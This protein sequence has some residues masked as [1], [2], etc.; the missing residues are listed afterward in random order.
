MADYKSFDDY[1]NYSLDKRFGE[2]NPE[3]P[4]SIDV[5]GAVGR[6]EIRP[7]EEIKDD[8]ETIVKSGYATA[9]GLVQG[10]LGIFGEL[11]HVLNGIANIYS[12]PE[13]QQKIDAFLEGMGKK[14][15]LPDAMKMRELLNKVIPEA[16]PEFEIAENIAEAVGPGK[17][18][19]K[20]AAKAAKG[21]KESKEAAIIAPAIEVK[22]KANNDK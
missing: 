8:Y 11:E 12:R 17:L 19:T 14:S 20:A 9:K 5:G 21:F 3:P 7:Q 16:D 13:G 18:L 1:F 4:E 15:I 22:E 2:V 10:E 6:V